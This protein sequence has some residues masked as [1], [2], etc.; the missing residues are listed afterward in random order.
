MLLMPL[1]AAGL[2]W[3]EALLPVVFILIWIISQITKIVRKQSGEQPAAQPPRPKPPRPR[4]AVKPADKP[5]EAGARVAPPPR[6]AEPAGAGLDAELRR[7]IE[8]FLKGRPTEPIQVDRAGPPPMP[9]K[10]R[11]AS[12]P[13]RRQPKPSPPP[14]RADVGKTPIA[15]MP[16]LSSSL[17]PEASE[18]LTTRPAAASIAVAGTIAGL[19]ADP[20][21]IRQAIVLKEVL[22]RPVERWS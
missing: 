11:P 14:Q 7:Q 10:P 12:K 1:F 6:K 22:D 21:S 18:E 4:P 17:R 20:R 8:Q 3:L 15:E 19:L 13:Q 16:H 2:D 5:A 9:P